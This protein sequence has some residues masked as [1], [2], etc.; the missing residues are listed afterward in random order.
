[1]NDMILT[2][3]A[4]S[5]SVKFALFEHR[6]EPLL[7]LR[8]RVEGIGSDAWLKVKGADGS[9][10]LTR[11]LDEGAIR[12]PGD[13]LAT[14]IDIVNELAPDAQICA[15]GH[16]IV[17]GGVTFVGPALLD[18]TTLEALTEL[19]PFAPLHQP[20]NLAGVEACSAAFPNVPQIGCF[21]TSFHRSHPWVNDTFALPQKLY[22]SGVRRFGFHGLSYEYIAS[23][24]RGDGDQRVIV[25]HLGNGA[26]MCALRDGKSVGSTMGF[27]ALD[28]LPMGTRCGQLDPGI[29]L[30][31][32]DQLAMS[33]KEIEHMLYR[34]SGL[35]G[36]SGISSDMRILLA[37]KETTAR[38]AIDY[39][40]FRIRREIGAMAA[41]LGGLDT[42]VFTGGIGENAV[43]IRSE[44]CADMQWLGMEL[45][46]ANNEANAAC[47]SASNSPVRILVTPTNEELMI[48]RHVIA[49]IS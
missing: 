14:I 13:A 25:A 7:A 8:G 28:G 43:Q 40:V 27:S 3:N 5:S 19:T 46:D 31:M 12:S 30:Y 35:K 47:I 34:E 36:L 38:S 6:R 2:L 32:M 37:S 26:S 16:R 17:H 29:L 33:A 4:G 49:Q 1:M 23:Q 15:I 41:V 21:D 42:L 10:I 44:I 24:M 48:A 39:F 11:D 9:T 45:D 22:D 18:K 20:H